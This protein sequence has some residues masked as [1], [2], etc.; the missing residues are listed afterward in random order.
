MAGTL[1]SPFPAKASFMCATGR[2]RASCALALRA[3]VGPRPGPLSRER[4]QQ[5]CSGRADRRRPCA[6]VRVS[7]T[8]SAQPGCASVWHRRVAGQPGL[9]KVPPLRTWRITA[10][11]HDYCCSVRAC[12]KE[13]ECTIY[14]FATGSFNLHPL[15][16]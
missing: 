14:L 8:P 2:L 4:E 10:A 12:S 15:L 9:A 1:S 5:H 7:P 13:E 11:S 16:V 6:V 3:A